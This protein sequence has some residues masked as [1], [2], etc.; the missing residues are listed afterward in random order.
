VRRR[1]TP[2]RRSTTRAR[3]PTPPTLGAIQ[4]E[5]VDET[6]VFEDNKSK[7][8]VSQEAQAS[9][10]MAFHKMLDPRELHDRALDKDEIE[11]ISFFL[12]ANVD[13]FATTVVSPRILQALLAESTVSVVDD[14]ETAAPMYEPSKPSD[15][16]TVVLQGQLHIVC[17]SEGFESDRGPWTVLAVGALRQPHY[18]PDFTV[19]RRSARAVP[20]LA[21][22]VM[23]RSRRARRHGR[24]NRRASCRSRAAGTH[25]RS[26]SRNG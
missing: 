12:A 1:K 10:R 13:H 24:P 26:R 17:G 7:K 15:S 9:R 6:D 8:R 21:R 2:A 11:A 23:D 25:R 20:P 3:E 4:A 5:I 22:A 19:W 16:C 14:P 18:V